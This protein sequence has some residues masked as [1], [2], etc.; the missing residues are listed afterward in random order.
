M[1]HKNDRDSLTDPLKSCEKCRVVWHTATR[2]VEPYKRGGYSYYYDF[3]HY[4][5][6]KINCPRCEEVPDECYA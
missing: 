6:E 2:L 5:L 1:R 3:P 4:G